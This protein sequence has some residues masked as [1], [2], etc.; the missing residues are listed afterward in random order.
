MLVATSDSNSHSEAWY[1]DIGCSNHM[2][3]HKEWLGDFDENK[4]SKIRLADSRTL[5]AEGT[6]NILIQRKDRKKTKEICR[7]VFGPDNI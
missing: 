6:R 2:T 4:R 1:L 3:G 7:K 5:S